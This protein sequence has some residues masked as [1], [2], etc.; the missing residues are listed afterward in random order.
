MIRP[1]SNTTPEPLGGILGE[2]QFVP[3]RF[4][5]P[6]GFGMPASPSADRPAVVRLAGLL[7]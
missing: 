7:H 3:L 5:D 6:L 1:M 2:L 4:N